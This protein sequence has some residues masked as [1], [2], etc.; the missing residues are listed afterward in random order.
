M[1]NELTKIVD[2]YFNEYEV[3]ETT[4][5]KNYFAVR[6]NLKSGGCVN[7]GIERKNKKSNFD[8]MYFNFFKSDLRIKD[9]NS[10]NG[11]INKFS[12][13]MYFLHEYLG[14]LK[15]LLNN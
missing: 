9:S 3:I 2:L 4:E 14:E 6:I 13:C 7:I 8:F 5:P 15:M 1:K 11:K 10:Y 12:D